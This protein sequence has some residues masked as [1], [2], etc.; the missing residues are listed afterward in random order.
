MVC[1]ETL[2]L[3]IPEMGAPFEAADARISTIPMRRAIL[4]TVAIV[5]LLALTWC[6]IV[7]AHDAHNNLL[8]SERA[9]ADIDAAVKVQSMNLAAEEAHLDS[10]LDQ[11]DKA[12]AE[13][14]AYWQKTSA[15]SDKTVKALRLTVDRASLLLDHADKELNGKLLPDLDG[16]IYLTAQSAQGALSSIDHAGSAVAFQV[17]A[18]DLGPM[19]ANLDESSARLANSMDYLQSASGHADQILGSGERTARYYERKLTTPASFVRKLSNFILQ[20]GSEARIL[21]VGH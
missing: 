10:V 16:Q 15:D 19:F 3:V 8:A 2:Q 17:D 4:E 9:I 11:V 14:R 6:T 18:L 1:R 12:A 13:Q 5:A 20:S 7:L 21:F